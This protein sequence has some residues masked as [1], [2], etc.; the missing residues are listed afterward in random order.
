MTIVTKPEFKKNWTTIKNK[1][2]TRKTLTEKNKK[3]ALRGSSLKMLS[4]HQKKKKCATVLD[5]GK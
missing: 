1:K 2:R 3:K 4:V 5:L